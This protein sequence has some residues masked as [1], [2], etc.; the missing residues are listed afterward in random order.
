[1]DGLH[2]SIISVILFVILFAIFVFL[3]FYGSRWR[4]GDLSKLSE[5]ALAGRRLGP[6][7]MWF[8]LTA[9]LFTAYTFIA[10]PSLVLASGPIGFFAAFYSGVTPFIALLFMPRLWAISRNRGYVT[11]ADFVKERF[12]SK[13]LA[14]LVAITGVVAELPYIALQ[15]V[16]MQAALFILLLGLGVSNITLASDLSLLVSFIILAAFVFTSGLRGA[17]LTAV[18]KDAIILISVIT[19]VIYV[20]LAFGGFSAAFHNA[21]T[22]S[23]QINLALNHVNKPIFYNYL[24]N[25]I[26]A[27]SAY[28]SLAIGSAFALYLYPHAVNGSV[29]AD[30]KQSLKVSLALQPFYSLILAI[31]ALFGILVYADINVVKFISSVKSGAIAVP[32]LIGYTMPDWFVGIALLGIFIGGLVPAA[33]MAIGAANLLTRNII[34]EFKP[35]MSSNTESALAKWISTAFKFLALVLV[36]TTPA[37][38]AIQLQLLGGII[39]LQTLPPVFLGLYTHKLN[40]YALT[41]GWVGG[42]FSGIYLT[43]LANHF[44]PLKTSS[45]LTPIGPMYIGAISVLINLAI[46]LIG[47]GIA[48]GIGWRPVTNIKSEELV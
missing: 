11:A 29:S 41:G 9:D 1:M 5:W 38:Y 40:G 17:A 13:L 15:I 7:L 43:L 44:G 22:L 31:I 8:L 20:P 32:A 45:F 25:T 24:P 36:F 12:N 46:G 23:N 33:I 2:V 34:K 27:Y 42:M 28:I 30:S 16:G 18:Y 47:T 35:N 4:R 21:A 26:S 48:Y 3:G 6:Y 39:I 14:G 37:T 10:V 19:V